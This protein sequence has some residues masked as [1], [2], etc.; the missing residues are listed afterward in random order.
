MTIFKKGIAALKQIPFFLWSLPRRFRA[1]SRNQKIATIVFILVLLGGGYKIFTRSGADTLAT[2]GANEREVALASVGDLASKRTALPLIGSITSVSE[3]TIRAETSGQITA[4]YKKLGDYVGAGG[5][6]AIIENSREKAAVEQ[7]QAALASAEAAAG[8]SAISGSNQKESLDQAKVNAFNTILSAYDSVD[9]S[10][11]TKID[12]MFTDASLSNPKFMVL[13][14]NSQLTTNINFER[15]KVTDILNAEV[16]RKNSL[17]AS[18]DL[19]AELTKAES[20]LRYVKTFVDDIASALN[21]STPT[22]NISQST[23]DG[24]K[25]TVALVRNSLNASLSSVSAA[26]DN[27]NSKQAQYDISQKQSGGE[28]VTTSGAALRQAQAALRIAEVN[29]EK[30]IIRSPINGTINSFS[31]EQGDY[32][33]A[34][35]VVAIV[36][37]NGALEIRAYITED[38]AREIQVGAQATIDGR[39]SGIVTRVAPALDPLTKKIEVRIGIVSGANTLLN[40]QSVRVDI[41]RTASKLNPNQKIT[42]PISAIKITADGPMVF[43]VEG[44]VLKEHPVTEGAL[45][46]DSIELLSGATPDMVIVTDARGLKDGDSVITKQ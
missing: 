11:R 17:S 1:L 23:I 6:I 15:L 32:V 36:S 10:V 42:V 29:L 21:Q 46:G 25:A 34:F 7:A 5:I 16:A 18:S 22:Q 8:I 45:L 41:E 44:G 39:L 26:R 13:T 38:D 35:Q 19:S 9:D 20:D 30:T 31:L 24:Y 2:L 4:V 40:G 12:P 37:N 14:S 27:L 3:A 33:T 43:T 28:G